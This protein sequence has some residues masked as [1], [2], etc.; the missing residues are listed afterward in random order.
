MSRNLGQC[1]L[2]RKRRSTDP[3]AVFDTLP[4]PVRAWLRDATL[5]WS[6]T[7]ALRIWRKSVAKGMNAEDVVAELDLVELKTLARETT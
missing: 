2:R 3:M 4:A 1:G 7:S 5:P 6:P